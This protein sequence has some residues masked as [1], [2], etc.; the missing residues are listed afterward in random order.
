MPKVSVIIPNYKHATY[1][2]RRIES[3]QAQTF[4][5]FELII[6]DDA[7][8]DNSREVIERYAKAHPEIITVFNEK[9]SGSP[10]AQWNRGFEMAK[11][12]YLWFAESDD[13]CEPTFLEKLVPLLE[14]NPK[15]GIAHAQSYLVNE[16]DE[17]INSY[18]KNLKFIYKSNAWDEDFI[19]DGREVCREWL[20]FHNP[21]P[22]ASGAIIRKQAFAD[23]GKA[24]MS[25]K[26][27]GDWLI[28]AKILSKY[29][30]AFC[31]E[32]LNYFRMHEHTQRS[33]A[34][35]NPQVY[36]EIVR[37]NEYIRTHVPESEENAR[38]GMQK[39]SDW[40]V[41]NL[42]YHRWNKT[43]RKQN[44]MLYRQFKPYRDQLP[45]RILLTLS[46]EFTRD[47][48]YTTGLIKPAKRLRRWM[49]PGKYFEYGK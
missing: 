33:R 17:I 45:L 23:A 47:F 49:F 12:E 29:D 15:V 7:S 10:F 25:M 16:E 6:F 43:A 41:G 3:V 36:A 21:I 5:D 34:R 40:W 22:N 8:P 2:P 1:L 35:T 11:G 9:N 42:Y 32:H 28:Y 30:L 37:I 20:L 48:L 39:V 13:Y 46:I 31:A 44:R 26:L 38:A 18:R 27:N 4:R 19:K 24:D 14:D